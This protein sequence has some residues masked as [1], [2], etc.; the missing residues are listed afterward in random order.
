[1]FDLLQIIPNFHPTLQEQVKLG[2]YSSLRQ[3][4]KK[5]V[6]SNLGILFDSPKLDRELRNRVRVTFKEFCVNS[7]P[8]GRIEEMPSIVREESTPEI[9]NNIYP[10]LL[11]SEP[12]FSDD[13][14]THT[15][16]DDED[17]IPLG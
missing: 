13:E 10:G 16:N 9:P 1:M 17:D 3:I 7:T 5:K 2:I 8:E 14:E 4:L 15:N 6:L 11:D 12:T